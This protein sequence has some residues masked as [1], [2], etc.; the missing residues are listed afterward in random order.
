MGEESSHNN[1]SVHSEE[2]LQ[3]LA[4][5]LNFNCLNE[6]LSEAGFVVAVTLLARSDKHFFVQTNKTAVDK[7]ASMSNSPN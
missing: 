4:V 2:L 7:S 1:T 6:V 3:P 5:F